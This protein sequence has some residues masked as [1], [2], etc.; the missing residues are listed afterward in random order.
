MLLGPNGR[1]LIL[2]LCLNVSSSL[3][4]SALIDSRINHGVILRPVLLRLHP[5]ACQTNLDMTAVS[6]MYSHHYCMY[7]RRAHVF[8]IIAA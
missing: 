2:L 1:K 5:L 8:W 6:C 7:T 3:L 4:V